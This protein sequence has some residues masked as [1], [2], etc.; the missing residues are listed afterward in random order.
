MIRCQLPRIK[1]SLIRV[2]VPEYSFK[3]KLIRIELCSYHNFQIGFKY[4][5]N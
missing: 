2:K 3:A 5:S 1:F 4:Q